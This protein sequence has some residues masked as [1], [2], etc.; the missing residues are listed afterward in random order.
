MKEPKSILA[1]GVIAAETEEEAKYLAGP[2]ELM[3]ARMATG[4]SDLSFPT[5]EEASKYVYTP[6]EEA[7]RQY[8]KGR[9]VIG[10]AA[11]VAE[12]LK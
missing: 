4:S 1:I 10:S 5:R 6:Q 3:W 7:A 11:N 2:L 8:N 12:N 9:F